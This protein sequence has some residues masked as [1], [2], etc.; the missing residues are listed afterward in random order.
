M[1]RLRRQRQVV[2]TN[3]FAGV[4]LGDPRRER[5]ALE[6]ARCL[7]AEP[8]A[9]LPAAM[10][11]RARLEGLYRHLGNDAVS[12]ARLIEPHI[13]KTAGRIDERGDVYAV[14][15]TTACSFGGVSR[16]EGLGTVNLKDQGFLAHVTLAVAADGS[17]L[18]LGVLAAELLVRRERKHTRRRSTFERARE[19]DKES[20]RWARGVRAASARVADP[21]RLVHVADR[22]GDMYELLAELR[23]EGA[24]FII[25]SAQDR[26]VDVGDV[27]TYLRDAAQEAPT[28]YTIQ[29]P[30]SRRAKVKWP[31]YPHPPRDAR[32]ATLSIATASVELRR[33]KSAANTLPRSVPMHVVH[34]F[35]LGAPPGEP[36]VEWV[37]LTS[38]PITT[39]EQVQTILEGYRTRWTIEEYFKAV[40]TGCA[41]EARQLESFRT[42][43]NLLAF[44][45]VVAYA[46]LLM[47]ALARTERKLPASAVLSDTELEVL[48]LASKK[49][50]S[51]DP[52][53][54]EAMLAIAALGGHLPSNGNPGWRVLSRGW[55]RLRDYEAGFRM[56]R[57]TCDR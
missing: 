4:D 54:R 6:I 13:R 29:V 38:E 42:L 33:P 2:V 55:Q 16:R 53:V 28:R 51:D 23:T 31:R 5:R 24:R 46:L 45:L 12:F 37:L 39:R 34:V 25:R 3:E 57:R 15:D 1:S 43:S 47:R 8:E 19:R 49:P 48:R 32:V 10:F 22:E 35:E 14:H 30:L 7:A 9:S 27:R 41:F 11:D 50:L 21:A 20:A 36:P 52:D 40:K 56:A 44:T 26:A 18:P 17:R